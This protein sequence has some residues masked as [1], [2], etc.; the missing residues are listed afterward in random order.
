[1]TTA[2]AR[3]LTD[4]EVATVEVLDRDDG[5]NRRAR[6]GVTYAPGN[7]PTRLLR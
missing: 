1:M 3:D 5:T 7:R 6:L 4:V 2:L